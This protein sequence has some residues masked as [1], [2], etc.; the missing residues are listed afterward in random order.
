MPAHADQL[1]RQGPGHRKDALGAAL[2]STSRPSRRREIRPLLVEPVEGGGRPQILHFEGPNVLEPSKEL[3]ERL[4]G[5]Q[6]YPGES[7]QRYRGA[8]DYSV[9]RGIRGVL[10]KAARDR[11][12]QAGGTDLAKH[13]DAASD[14][15]EPCLRRFVLTHEPATEAGLK[16]AGKEGRKGR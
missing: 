1:D 6:G 7:A 14:R 9:Q 11:K 4:A 3:E 5:C 2:W 15:H 12:W 10:V 16:A 8:F 13:I